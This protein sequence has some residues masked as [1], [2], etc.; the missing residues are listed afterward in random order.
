MPR[1]ILVTAPRV[2]EFREYSEPPLKAGEVRVKSIISGI[3]HG[4][5]MN[6]YRGT[7]PFF[8]QNF[9][10]DYRLFLPAQPGKLYPCNLGSWLVGEVMEI[11]REVKRFRIGD[12]VH[13]GLKHRE[14]NVI[15]EV[16]LHPL[17]AMEVED[18][19]FVDPGIFALQ[20][21]H[22]AGIKVGDHVAVFGMGAIGLLAVQMARLDGAEMVIAVDLFD[23][24][25]NLARRL[26]A[27]YTLNA[28][29]QDVGWEIKKLTN[30]KGVDVALEI[31]G[32]YTA[33]H[34]AIRSV[35]V[36]GKIVAASYYSG[37]RDALQLGAEWHH[38]RPVLISSM[39]VWGCLHRDY[40]LWDLKR[41]IS[42][43]IYLLERKIL[44]TEG[45]ISHRFPFP[46]AMQA[47]KLIDQ[48]PEETIKVTLI[49]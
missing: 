14:T 8:D 3:K 28:G 12:R 34:Q 42:T 43:V 32:S 45:L 10:L 31:S 15:P 23:R 25:L 40:P 13:G 47:Y 26:G 20:T 18:A 19:L 39:A 22:D 41:I 49:Y 11:G 2:I 48:H 30:K 37:S 38:N 9:D 5:E 17:G 4:T 1:E 46:E 27:D 7:S 21:V 6:L 36:G 16:E 35:A 33:L 44:R 24:R 29:E